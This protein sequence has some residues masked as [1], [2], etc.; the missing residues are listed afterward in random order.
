M[1]VDKD[2]VEAIRAK[3]RRFVAEVLPGV[4]LLVPVLFLAAYVFIGFFF[5]SANAGMDRETRMAGAPP[6]TD[7][8]QRLLAAT[9]FDLTVAVNTR[10]G[11]PDDVLIRNRDFVIRELEDFGIFDEVVPVEESSDADLAFGLYAPRCPDSG[12]ADGSL[13]FRPSPCPR[14]A[15]LTPP[16]SVAR[17]LRTA[18]RSTWPSP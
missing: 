17:S 18:T 13:V 12:R 9:H 5:T 3:D 10:S 8:E 2:R 14:A 6:L 16:R 4:L 7:A 11:R 15:P 1:S